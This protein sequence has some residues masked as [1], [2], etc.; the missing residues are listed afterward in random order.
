LLS[1]GCCEFVA[2]LPWAVSVVGLASSV[3]GSVREY[4]MGLR[5]TS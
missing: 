1:V 3:G 4:P 2:E 5:D